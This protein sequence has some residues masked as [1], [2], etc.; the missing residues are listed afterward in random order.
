MA[1]S[2][3]PILLIHLNSAKLHDD[4]YRQAGINALSVPQTPF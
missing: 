2:L 1:T 4:A 3:I